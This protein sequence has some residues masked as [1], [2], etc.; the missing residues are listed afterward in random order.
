M[1]SKFLEGKTLQEC[2]DACG[3]VAERWYDILD[4]EG[5][6][7]DDSELIEYIG[8]SRFL[9]RALN[10]YE[11]QKGPMITCAHRLSEFLGPEIVKGKGINVKFIIA[12]KP[13]DAKIA[14]RAIPT[15]IFEA[16]PN[17]MKKFLRKWLKDA[18]L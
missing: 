10:E 6:Y 5:E 16:D 9:S 2:Y 11:G 13:V 3:E 15:A 17:V 4:T 1:F 12:R 7:I 18:G 14:E 8:E